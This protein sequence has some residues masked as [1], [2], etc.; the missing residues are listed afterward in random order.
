M[1]KKCTCAWCKK[2]IERDEAYCKH[3]GKHN[4][5]YCNEEEFRLAMERKKKREE[6][7]RRQQQL[8]AQKGT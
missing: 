5:F 1:S 7:K 3:A 6:N 8:E 2:R 4:T